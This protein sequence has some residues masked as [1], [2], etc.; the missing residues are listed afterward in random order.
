MPA[1][2]LR[3]PYVLAKSSGWYWNPT[4]ALRDLGF[5]P[6]FLGS[7]PAKAAARHAEL[8]AAVEAARQRRKNEIPDFPK[9]PITGT[10]EHLAQTF[11]GSPVHGIEPSEQWQELSEKSREDYNRYIDVIVDILRNELVSELTP[12]IIKTLRDSKYSRAPY[13]GNYMLRVFSSMLRIA[14][15]HSS[16]FNLPW[17]FDPINFSDGS[18]NRGRKGKGLLF[19]GKKQGIR[20]RVEFYWS[21]EDENTFLKAAETDPQVKVGYAL[22]TYTGQRLSDVLAMKETDYDGQK[23]KVRQRKTDKP[24][25]IHVHKDLK[26]ILD[27]HLAVK[28]EA[29]RIGGTL[30]YTA[31]GEPFT[32]RWFSRRWDDVAKAAGIYVSPPEGAPKGTQR[33]RDSLQ[34]RDLRRTAVLRLADAG[35]NTI[36]IRS[37]TGHGIATIN[38]MLETYLPRSYRQTQAA[39]T[40]LEEYAAG[41]M[42]NDSQ[43][44]ESENP[45]R[46][47]KVGEPD[48]I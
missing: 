38:E 7:D 13:A 41:R 11:R 8:W 17:G 28:R 35:C 43:K 42:Q 6:E 37:I 16:I 39:I 4:R 30:L 9:L 22:L 31:S 20:T 32:K 40:R 46:G 1:V 10:I 26:A 5:R 24:L 21:P 44:I 27:A 2:M 15:M 23:V 33:N 45:G 12:E 34:R 14:R 3:L 19:Y 18:G 47:Q 48:G 25:W 36:E 29:G